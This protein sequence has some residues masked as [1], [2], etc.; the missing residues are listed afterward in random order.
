MRRVNA[1]PYLYP[2]TYYLAKVLSDFFVIQWNLPERP[3]LSGHLTKI[4]IPVSQI[5]ISESSR[6]RP[7]PI[8]DHL[9]LTS[10]T[11]M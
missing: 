5:A 3:L 11:V 1:P 7:P 4:P 6:K 10:R 2:L 8:S 9:S